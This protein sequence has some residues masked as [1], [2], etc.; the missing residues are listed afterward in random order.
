MAFNFYDKKTYTVYLNSEDRTNA[1]TQYYGGACT[2]QGSINGRQMTITSGITATGTATAYITSPMLVTGNYFLSNTYITSQA[3]GTTGGL[4]VYNL[5]VAP[6]EP[7][8]FSISSINGNTI[9][10]SSVNSGVIGVGMYINP[11]LNTTYTNVSPTAYDDYFIAP[12]TYVIALGTGTGG[13]GTYILNQYQPYSLQYSA[14]T[15]SLNSN[16]NGS[17]AGNQLTVTSL[18]APT[19]VTCNVSVANGSNI[20]T[21]AQGAIADGSIYNGMVLS[22]NAAINGYT[23]LNQITEGSGAG[24]GQG[25]YTLSN[26]SSALLTNNSVTFTMN[27]LYVGSV[28]TSTNT[29]TAVITGATTSSKQITIDYTSSNII[30]GMSI[31]SLAPLCDIMGS[32]SG[33][34]LTV[35]SVSTV[36]YPNMD[37]DVASIR[38]QRYQAIAIENEKIKIYSLNIIFDCSHII[39]ILI[40]I[41]C[42]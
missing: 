40:C 28:I 21:I 38:L 39:F 34:I 19:T 35:T 33:N 14:S 12:N 27:P 8:S 24:G 29:T 37:V 2:A 25:T 4:G 36:I 41:V 1:Y 42:I 13:A 5:N 15:Y 9:T 17:I 23:I 26:N 7:A 22:G 3:S 20:L 10:V 18:T 16:F 31:V 6:A 32:I 30:L 11:I